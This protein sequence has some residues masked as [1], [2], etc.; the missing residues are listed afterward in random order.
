[1]GLDYRNRIGENLTMTAKPNHVLPTDT[2]R[3]LRAA[4]ERALCNDPKAPLLVDPYAVLLMFWRADEL[5]NQLERQT[6]VLE[7]LQARCF[8]QDGG[9]EDEWADA[10]NEWAKD[11]GY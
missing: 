4:C 3:D 11:A 9:P 10:A 6:D 2:Y 1:M 5:A 8:V 7:E